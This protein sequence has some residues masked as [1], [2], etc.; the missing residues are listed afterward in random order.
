MVQAPDGNQS[1][2]IKSPCINVCRVEAA[3]DVCIG[4]YRTLA[5]IA[6]WQQMSDAERDRVF[7]VL[8]ARR[9]ALGSRGGA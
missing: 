8:P 2:V 3:Q 1:C 6:C 4:C 9:R 7:E 5:E